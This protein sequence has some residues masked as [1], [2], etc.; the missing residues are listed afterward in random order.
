MGWIGLLAILLTVIVVIGV[1]GIALLLDWE[2]GVSLLI[3]G[4]IIVPGTIIIGYYLYRLFPL[5]QQYEL[6][7]PKFVR[8]PYCGMN[9]L[10]IDE[11]CTRCGNALQKR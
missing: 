3:I 8:C 7:I 1:I 10:A 9:N 6:G 4:I 2:F 11:F 5:M